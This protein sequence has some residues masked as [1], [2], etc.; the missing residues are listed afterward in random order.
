VNTNPMAELLKKMCHPISPPG[1]TSDFIDHPTRRDK[2]VEIGVV[3]QHRFA[4][5]YW[6]KWRAQR[7]PLLQPPNL[8]TIDW[9]DDVGGDCDFTPHQIR[10]LDPRD[11]NE[12]SLFCWAG[13]R[14]LND[15]QIAPAQYLNAIGD[16]YVILKQFK[17][18][19]KTKDRHRT[20]LDKNG[21]AHQIYYY[22]TPDDFL[23][24]HAT[25]PAHPL[26]LDLDLDY[27]TSEANS[28]EH[29]DQKRVSDRE[30]KKVVSLDRPLMRWILP[31]LDGF[32]IAL[33]P[34]Y[35]GGVGNCAHILNV[36]SSTLCDPPLL[37]AGMKWQ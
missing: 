32:T 11:V 35:C 27:F 36:V 28:G 5:F 31:R 15:G 26:I 20:Q 16:V 7:E 9:H 29:G 24:A 1:C 18:E 6:L 33:E 8:L 25:D 14:S 17:E 37:S 4:F 10:Q 23:R 12:L 22:D 30:I 34:K 21:R 2:A 19:K 13:L 3:L